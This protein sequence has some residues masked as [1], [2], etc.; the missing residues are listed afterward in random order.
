[1]GNMETLACIDMCVAFI[2]TYLTLKYNNWKQQKLVERMYPSQ[3]TG[4]NIDVAYKIDNVE[5]A[6]L[7]LRGVN[8]EDAIDNLTRMFS[9]WSQKK[10]MKFSEQTKTQ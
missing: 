7:H 3:K 2:V 1:M 5:V 4:L 8:L 6:G 10:D 9:S